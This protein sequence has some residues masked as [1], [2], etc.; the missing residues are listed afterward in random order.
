MHPIKWI[1]VVL[2]LAALP[3]CGPSRAQQKYDL[4]NLGI[5]YHMYDDEHDQG[6]PGWDELEKLAEATNNRPESIRRVK[7]AGYQ[8][9]WGAKF[10]ELKDGTANTVMAKPPGEGL[11]LMMDGS[12]R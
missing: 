11:T 5:V 8:V 9:T 12:V 10:A 3:G 6:P 7:E 4:A 2:G 1:W